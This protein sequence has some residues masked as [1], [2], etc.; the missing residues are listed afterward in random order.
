MYAFNIK[1]M[2][3]KQNVLYDENIAAAICIAC[4]A[5]LTGLLDQFNQV[6]QATDMIRNNIVARSL[7]LGT[8][9]YA[10]NYN[11]LVALFIALVFIDINKI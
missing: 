11:L 4:V 3:L 9:W 7:T 1:V 8:I 5:Y 6:K 10:A 2:E